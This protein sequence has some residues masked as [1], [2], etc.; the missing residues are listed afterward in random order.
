MSEAVATVG[1]A[2]VERPRVGLARIALGLSITQI[3]TYLAIWATLNILLP[4]QIEGAV[5]AAGKEAW[6]GIITTVGALVAMVASPVIGALSDKTRSPLGRRAPW[7]LAGGAATLVALNIVGATQLAFVLLVGW[8]LT[9]LTVNMILMPLSSVLPERVPH[10]RRGVIS[11]VSGFATTFA[12]ALSAFVGA[13]FVGAPL[14]GTIVLSVLA[15]AGAVAYVVLAPDNSSRDMVV[16]SGGG[17]S[18]WRT[19]LDGFKDHNFRWTWAG[20]FLVFLGYTLLSTRMLY[21]VQATFGSSTAD[22]A[23]TV[24]TVTAIGGLFMVVGLVVSA[25]L[26][27]RLG[28]KPFVYL[29]GVLIAVGL[30]LSAFATDVTQLIGAW[31]VVSLALGSFVGVDQALVADILPA[32]EEIAKDLGVINLA[33]TLPQTLGPAIGSVVLALAGGAYP[34]LIAV[35][36]VSALLS[37]FATYRIRGVR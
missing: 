28:R 20:R 34:A 15:F 33:A 37:V 23:T 29:G 5:G 22:A 26:S 13:A 35:G 21:F 14:T 16:A 1:G 30:G 18:M 31:A 2:V 7:I 36:A 24:A 10:H 3:T 27:D 4:V 6:L 11:G 17:P 8:V 25:P 9:Q 32:K 12:I 19:L